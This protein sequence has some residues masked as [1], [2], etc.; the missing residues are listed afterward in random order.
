MYIK[1]V[2]KMKARETLKRMT[3][4]LCYFPKDVALNKLLETS[5]FG[6]SDSY[7]I[8]NK[9]LEKAVTFYNQ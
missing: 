1:F 7:F 9:G 4:L 3:K 6:L 2:K 5:K 8:T